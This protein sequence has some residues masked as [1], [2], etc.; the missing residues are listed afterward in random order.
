MEVNPIDQSN[1]RQVI[2]DFPKQLEAGLALAKDITSTKPTGRIIVC[3]MGGSGLPADI[4]NTLSSPGLPIIVHKDYGLLPDANASDL[5]ICISYSGNTEETV[6]ALQEAAAKNI[7]AVVIATGGELER[8][9]RDHQL[10]FVKLPAGIQPRSAIGYMSGALAML[11]ENVGIVSMSSQFIQAA[12]D[13]AEAT[14]KLEAEAQVMAKKL[15]GKI[16][17]VYASDRLATLAKIW[18]IRFNEN[19]KI[20]AFYNVFPE[21]NHNELAGYEGIKS[22]T[23]KFHF[24]ILKDADDHP[25]VQKRMELTADIAKES[26]ADVSILATERG[27]LVAK[28]FTSAVLSDWVSYYLALERN[29][30]PTPV[31]VVEDF[32]KR[33]LS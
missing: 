24:I 2:L 29:I 28:F 27:S 1:M 21:L 32:K 9:S 12:K 26:G 3:G 16:P 18:K 5:V 20:P 17:V 13:V 6:S 19:S 11:L 10:P 22:V 30:N 23:G 7:P 4:L 25:R 33:L 31:T 8:L 14:P 15:N